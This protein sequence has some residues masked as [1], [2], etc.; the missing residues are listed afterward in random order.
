[1][2]ILESKFI[3]YFKSINGLFQKHATLII[4]PYV[5]EF[6]WEIM[7]WIPYI[8]KIAIKY[9]KVI[10]ISYKE[11]KYFYKDFLFCPHDLKLGASGFA[12]GKISK[13]KE[14]EIINDCI[15]KFNLNKF[16][17]FKP[18]YLNKISKYILG[19]KKYNSYKTNTNNI[20]ID[21]LFHFRNFQRED[22][23]Y[24]NYDKKLSD[25]IANYFL[26]KNYKLACIGHPD[27]AYCPSKVED[28]RSKDFK[29]T[30]DI[31]SQSRIVVGGSSGPMHLAC[32]CEKPII[33]WISAEFGAERYLSYW[34]PFKVP[35]YI[36]SDKSFKPGKEKIIENIEKALKELSDSQNMRKLK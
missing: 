6:G 20:T 4:G 25:D 31:I 17:L 28:F 36:V 34:N 26:L 35:V 29:D 32:L 30:I 19:E 23:D 15:L 2:N 16:D 24:K 12:F 14:M 27:L 3:N 10:S 33:T 1:M 11:S 22:G 18:A 8:N 21:I 5:G 7:E 13:E 9:N